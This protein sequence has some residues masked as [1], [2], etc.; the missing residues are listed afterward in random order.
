MPISSASTECQTDF[1][2]QEEHAPE[3][4][5][6]KIH[7]SSVKYIYHLARQLDNMI[8]NEG[9]DPE[10]EFSSSVQSPELR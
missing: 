10:Q 1:F 6:D 2:I 9:K 8:Q 5:K 7:T 3:V 4:D